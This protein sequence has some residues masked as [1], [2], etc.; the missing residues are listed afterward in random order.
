MQTTKVVVHR[1]KKFVLFGAGY[2]FS[3]QV[4]GCQTSLLAQSSDSLTRV[5]TDSDGGRGSDDIYGSGHSYVCASG[6]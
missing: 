5:R 4:R 2:E 3:K 1:G 6:S